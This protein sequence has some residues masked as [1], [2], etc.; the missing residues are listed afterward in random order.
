MQDNKLLIG[1]VVII[2]LLVAIPVL[3]P[4]L[5]GNPYDPAEDARKME[6]LNK[7]I[8]SYVQSNNRPPS[9]L[10]AMVPD[11]LAEVPLNSVNSPFQ[12]DPRTGAVSNP[13]AAEAAETA[14][15][16]AEGGA[17]GGRGG[18]GISP[19]TDAM[20]GLGVSQELNF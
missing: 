15:Q 7:A 14:E 6:T 19:A 17:R 13:A 18:G 2:A 12:Y 16:S 10:E 1:G 9:S 3:G 8:S 4:M 20:T 5:R 11:Y